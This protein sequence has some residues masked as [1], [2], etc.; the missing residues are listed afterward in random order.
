[1][2]IRPQPGAQEAFL[3]SEA[4]IAFYG[5]AAGG[6]KTWALL[7]EPL[8]HAGNPNFGA[9]VFRRNSVQVRNEGGLW[10]E[11]AKLYP[12][13]GATPQESTLQWRFPSGAKLKFA[14][15][16]HEKTKL[17]WQ[18]SQIPLIGFD[19]NY[20]LQPVAVPVHAQPQPL[21]LRRAALHP[22]HHQPG[23]RQ[24]GGRLHRLVSRP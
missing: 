20:P 5:G 14:H 2:E 12:L 15:L 23:R 22:R 17:D 21:D 8:R 18:G 16:E 3:A 6:G 1:M 13:V 4:D 9:V 7:L 24:L 19:E 11:S 10:D